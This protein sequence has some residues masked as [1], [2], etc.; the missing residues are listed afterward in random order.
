MGK[1]SFS[2][3]GS[4]VRLGA[5]A[6]GSRWVATRLDSSAVDFAS[7]RNAANNFTWTKESPD[8]WM[9]TLRSTDRDGRP[10]TTV[11]AM[12]RVRR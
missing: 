7:E 3:I 5:V 6:G 2:P 4:G 9:A 12:E 1:R 8:R 11:Y 10:R